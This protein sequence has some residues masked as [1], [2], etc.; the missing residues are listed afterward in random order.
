LP[1][2]KR[3]EFRNERVALIEWFFIMILTDL[4]IFPW[5]VFG[6]ESKKLFDVILAVLI[7]KVDNE[8]NRS[9]VEEF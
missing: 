3:L 5:I 9:D 6:K 7:I 8:S 1:R 4:I 2:H